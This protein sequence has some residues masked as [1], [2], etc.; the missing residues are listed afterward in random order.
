M[1]RA[2]RIATIFSAI[3]ALAAWLQFSILP[4]INIGNSYPDVQMPL[5][6]T[7]SLVTCYFWTILWLD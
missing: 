4:T 3:A 1:R 2:T 5:A 7:L 6:V